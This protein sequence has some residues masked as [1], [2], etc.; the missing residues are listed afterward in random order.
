MFKL[1]LK[2]YRTQALWL[3]GTMLVGAA[4]AAT[5]DRLVTFTTKTQLRTDIM[6]HRRAPMETYSIIVRAAQNN[7]EAE[8]A[9]LYRELLMK[10]PRDPY[11]QSA[12]AFSHFMATGAGSPQYFAR[13]RSPLI[14][15]LAKKTDEAS[16]FRDKAIEALPESPVIVLETARGLYFTSF[17]SDPRS[18]PWMQK[19]L[20]LA[21][22]ATKLDPEWGAAHYWLAEM[23]QSYSMN[24]GNA[25][26]KESLAK[27]ALAEYHK[28][29]ELEP[30]RWRKHY[31][32]GTARA[33]YDLQQWDKSLKNLDAYIKLRPEEG[34][35]VANWRASLLKRVRN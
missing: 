5:K 25:S 30:S 33:Y 13:Q 28:M 8:T 21:R 2:T 32:V 1:L 7:L 23:L 17:G 26:N 27:E 22:K 34:K 12:Y 24:Q 18:I 31:L 35:N 19:G 16:Y 9:W 20:K 14:L 15:K 29:L 10:S 11:L 6:K 3:L 4:G